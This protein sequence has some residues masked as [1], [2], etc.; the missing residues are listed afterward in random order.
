MKN[1]IK[2]EKE[3]FCIFALNCVVGRIPLKTVQDDYKRSG[4]CKTKIG[5]V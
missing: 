3:E 2:S 4:A 5:Q 1:E